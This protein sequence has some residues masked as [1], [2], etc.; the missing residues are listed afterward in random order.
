MN[1]ATDFLAAHQETWDRLVHLLQPGGEAAALVAIGVDAEQSRE[2]LLEALVPVTEHYQH[3]LLDLGQEQVGS[4]V[5]VLNSRFADLLGGSLNHAVQHVVHVVHLEHTLLHE[6]LSGEGR[7]LAQLEAERE[8]LRS[9]FPFRLLLWVD[10]YLWRRLAHEAPQLWGLMIDQ[11]AFFTPDSDEAHA[12]PSDQAYLRLLELAAQTRQAE[13]PD[14]ALL[15][16]IGHALEQKGVIAPAIEH[17]EQVLTQEAPAQLHLQ[18]H[19]GLAHLHQQEG[20]AGEAVEAYDAALALAETAS[21][22]AAR[23]HEQQGDLYLRLQAVEEANEAFREALAA[24]QTHSDE[25]GQARMHRRLA[26]SEERKGQLDQAVRHFLQ[27]IELLEAADEPDVHHL[28]DAYQ[29]VGAIRQN[30]QRYAEALEAFAQALP[31]AQATEDA[32]LIAALEDSVEAMR[33]TLARRKKDNAK[34]P[35][36]PP[37]RKGLFGRLLG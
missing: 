10:G 31:F 18:A 11:F 1:Q 15:Y 16:E 19:E 30:Q 25:L 4:L 26:Y 6:I 22:D 29:Q 13:T 2:A 27:A 32:F 37:K 34:D 36:D 8:P 5:E 28:A 3:I 33:E 35:G 7:L 17:Y 21:V 14:P 23:L 24:Y 12:A 9:G 20:A